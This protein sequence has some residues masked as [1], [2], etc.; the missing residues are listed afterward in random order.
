M[1]QDQCKTMVIGVRGGL[2]AALARHFARKR[3]ASWHRLSWWAGD[4]RYPWPASRCPQ[5]RQQGRPDGLA[6]NDASPTG[7]SIA[8]TDRPGRVSSI[9]VPSGAV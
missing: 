1:S 5:R 9:V 8:N 7:N 2:G 6:N 4:H 3:A